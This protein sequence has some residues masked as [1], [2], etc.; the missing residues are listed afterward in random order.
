[1]S[2]QMEKYLAVNTCRTEQ[3]RCHQELSEPDL[4]ENDKFLI[5]L[6]LQDYFTEE[7]FIIYDNFTREVL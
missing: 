1:M 7:L 5:Q 4:T 2:R 3:A 6:G